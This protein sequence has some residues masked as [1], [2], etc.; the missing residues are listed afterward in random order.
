MGPEEMSH[1]TPSQFSDLLAAGDVASLVFSPADLDE[2]LFQKMVEP[3]IKLAQEMGI[4][5]IIAD[6]SR[7]AGR[8]KADGLQLGQDLAALKDAIDKLSPG[9]MVGAANV[10]TRHN[11]LNI[12]E[13]Q[14][15]YLMF[16]KPD[17]DI[18]P[19]P[20]P[21]NL[22]LGQ[23]WSEM[24]EIPCIVMG[25][26]DIESIVDVAKSGAEF[27]ALRAAIFAPTPDSNE[28]STAP[29]RVRHANQL[30]NDHAPRF[31][32]IED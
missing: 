10:K 21:K 27:V 30:L 9:M 29:D 1:F 6:Y 11:A 25:G 23:W 13:L 17:G 24:V 15:D 4:A 28:H 7:I 14:P 32:T 16:G 2:S 31:E 20:H 26:S 18:R 12:G 8:V 22:A 3:L 19:E 5:S